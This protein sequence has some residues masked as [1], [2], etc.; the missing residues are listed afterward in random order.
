MP[1]RPPI[2]RPATGRGSLAD[3]QGYDRRRRQQ[4]PTRPLYST[5]RWQ[6]VRAVQLR[7]EPLCRMCLAEDHVTPAVVCDH[8]TPHR[9]D[10]AAFWAGPYQSLCTSCHSSKKQREEA[11]R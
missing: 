11:G 1:T 2:F 3:Q 7:E 10:V 5:A 8:V 4:V 9:G 6:A